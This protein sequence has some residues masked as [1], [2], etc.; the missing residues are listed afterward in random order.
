[1]QT[2]EGMARQMISKLAGNGREGHVE[3]D[4]ATPATCVASMGET[5]EGEKGP[6]A[7]L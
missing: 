1:M 6:V 2:S 3:M 5:P 4:V 7:N